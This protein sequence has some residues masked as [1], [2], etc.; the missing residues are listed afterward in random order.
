M[1]DPFVAESSE[2]A[3]KDR[4]SLHAS[5]SDTFGFEVPGYDLRRIIQAEDPLAAANAFFVQILQFRHDFGLRIKSSCPCQYAF[6]SVAELIGG[7]AGRANAM[8]GAVECQE[9]TGSLHYH[10]FLSVQRLH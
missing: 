5:A 8:F 10:F 3:G 1:D 6:G 2:W 4:P 7:L 9:S